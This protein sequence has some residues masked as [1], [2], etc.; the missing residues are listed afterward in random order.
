MAQLVINLS[1]VDQ[2]VGIIKQSGEKA[3]FRLMDRGRV[4]MHAYK[5]DPQWLALNPNAVQVVELDPPVELT[6]PAKPPVDLPE[7]AKPV[8]AAESS[9]TGGT[10]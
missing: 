1:R 9:K 4:E 6:E 5:V 8:V 7:P 10:K 3:S 2:Q